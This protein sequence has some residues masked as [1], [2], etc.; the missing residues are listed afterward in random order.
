M[1]PRDFLAQ[2]ARNYE[3]S[4]DQEEVFL[5]RY[6]EEL[7]YYDIAKKLN[8]SE[9]ACLKRMGQV[10]NKF[11]VSGS[12]RGKENRLR[13]F[14]T[15]QLQ[16][17]V[18]QK[19]SESTVP[20]KTPKELQGESTVSPKVIIKPVTNTGTASPP[21]YENLP[22]R[23]CTTFIGRRQELAR[24]LELLSSEHSAHLISVD[25]VGGV[26][27]TTLVLE[28][29]H[30]CLEASQPGSV[31]QSFE[32]MTVPTFEAIIFTSAKQQYLK[33]LRILPRLKRER[34][35]RDIYRTIAHTLERPEISYRSPDDQL[36]LI[37]DSLKRQRTLLIVDN[38]ET[39]EDKQ[40]LLSFVYDLPR[41][42]KV[43]L[44]TREQALF[45]PIRL[46]SLHEEDALSLITHQAE[47]KGVELQPIDAKVL[48][49][50]THAIPA[51]I[52]YTVGQLAAGYSL[53]DVLTKLQSAT[54][55][56]ARFCFEASVERMR[57][58]PS[59]R[60]LMT[61]SLFP[62]PVERETIAEIAEEDS[63]NT[64]DGLA[65]LQQ[66]SLVRQQ[67]ARYRLHPLTR[68][69]ARAE[70]TANLEFEE[71]VRSRWV[72]WYL[73][74]SQ[75][76]G[77]IDEKKWYPEYSHIDLE[78]ENLQEV[79]KWC[80]ERE[81]ERYEDILTLWRQIK[82]YAH[83]RGY[84]DDR[85]MWTDWLQGATERRGDWSTLAEILYDKGWTLTLTR[86]PECLE[87][88]STLLEHAWDLRNHKDIT[89]QVELA[90]RMVVL[91][92]HQQKFELAHEWIKIKQ[93][94]LKQSGVEELERQRQQIQTHYYQAKI[95]F[96]TKDY[97]QAKKLYQRAL[98]QAKD[99]GWERA[100]IAIQNWLADV[101]IEEGNLEVAQQILEQGFPV[102]EC[103]K[104]KHSI[105]FHQRSFAYL[106][107]RQGNLEQA[108]TWAQE[109]ALSF[110]SL[111]MIPE[112]REMRTLLQAIE[113][114]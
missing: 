52:V 67:D 11:K 77:N 2:M 99:I 83:V 60:I 28:T 41:T 29:A 107:Q 87:E 20:A 85:L 114:R 50:N 98:K 80:R 46:E 69:Y 54:G 6:G 92:I 110:E 40:E 95:L 27:K 39:I 102:A 62:E 10:Y 93:N 26:G 103:N 31:V 86:Q 111:K 101:A 70:L 53:Q 113:D 30:R 96:L 42:V 68:E 90:A 78:W 106:L 75:K 9:G 55:D 12:S 37:R 16:Q 7:N 19:T 3:L 34:S 88:A 104:D 100:E 51:A 32:G 73:D 21:I 108:R 25:G 17:G 105:A 59:H 112:A 79:M 91:C 49:Q 8:T 82:G 18:T 71:K 36:D 1:L 43:I 94:M 45:V 23:E 33:A 63:M 65:K 81:K 64:G 5:L 72:E 13:I 76:Y 38:L 48:C 57:G 24:L 22:K 47:E 84:W 89:F 56:V 61:L 4:K 58:K 74:F 35:L 44:T 97:V 14:L 109:A 15:E 66:L